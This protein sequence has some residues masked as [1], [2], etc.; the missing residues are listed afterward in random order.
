MNIRL[1]TFIN[2]IS[3]DFG[4]LAASL[5]R[6]TR[7][8]SFF[9]NRWCSSCWWLS[10]NYFFIL[11]YCLIILPCG[12]MWYFLIILSKVWIIYYCM[13]VLHKLIQVLDWHLL[14][15]I[16]FSVLW[17]CCFTC[18]SLY[19]YNVIRLIIKHKISINIILWS[20]IR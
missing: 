19:L 12:F 6:G 3:N 17:S 10:N 20:T 14:T 1:P 7:R 8:W 9:I 13:L 16:R 15:V 2:L 5:L 18:C 4:L 11:Y